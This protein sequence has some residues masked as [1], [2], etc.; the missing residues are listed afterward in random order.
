VDGSALGEG[1][2]RLVADDPNNL[3]KIHSE[4]E[5]QSAIDWWDEVMSTRGNDPR[6]VA[7]VIVQQR[8]HEGDITG[9][10]LKKG[11]YVHLKLPAE[12]EG[13]ACETPIFR[14]PRTRPGE[15]LW[16]ERFGPEELSALKVELGTYGAAAQLQ[17]NPV[18]TGGGT[19]KIDWFGRYRT[20]PAS[21]MTTV[22]VD[23]AN[24]AKELSSYTVA[25]AFREHQERAYVAD[26]WRDRVEYPG[27]KRGV[28]SF[29]ERWHPNAV[30]I[31]DKGNGTALIQDLRKE[32][33]LPIIAVEPEGDKIMRAQ[34]TS[35][36]VESGLVLLPQFAPWA[37][38][39]EY[40]IGHFPAV[41]F[42]DQVDML[43]QFL[44][45][46]A[47]GGM[48]AFATA[49]TRQMAGVTR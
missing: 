36:S 41:D 45:R 9:H 27:L 14:D 4:T 40:E 6:T 38:D 11:G 24:K 26:V 1:G 22:S 32:T 17:Q 28:R 49:G 20:L 39:F 2:D 47:R 29:C 19:F 25:G 3:K 46:F 43:T 16:P 34:R 23:C 30:L 33:R 42:M 10:V 13:D 21:G 37:N 44:D 8:G 15:L 5:R 35:P 12:F 18:P 31:E 7:K 48:P